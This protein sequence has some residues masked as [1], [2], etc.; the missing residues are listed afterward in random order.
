MVDHPVR[1]MSNR[2]S[3][4]QDEENSHNI[5]QDICERQERKSPY[6]R[7]KGKVHI[8]E[9]KEKSMNGMEEN[10]NTYRRR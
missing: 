7:T 4:E 6:R 8:E 3:K 2:R 5:W 10:E 9:R 1:D